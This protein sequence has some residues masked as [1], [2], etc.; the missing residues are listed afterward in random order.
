MTT[1]RGRGAGD[2]TPPGADDFGRI[3]GIGAAIKGRLYAAGIL[4]FKELA[5]LSPDQIG[6]RVGDFPGKS[7]ELIQEWIAEARALASASQD[8]PHVDVP[9]PAEPQSD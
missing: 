5:E 2:V 8:G 9:V 6:A 4:T 3:H 7:A 1:K